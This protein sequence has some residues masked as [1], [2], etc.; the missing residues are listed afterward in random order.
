[1]RRA[2]PV[3]ILGVVLLSTSCTI[4]ERCPGNCD[5]VCGGKM[6]ET[7][8]CAV[9]YRSGYNTGFCAGFLDLDRRG[10][11]EGPFVAGYWDGYSDGSIVRVRHYVEICSSTLAT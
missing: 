3:M 10:D 1:M 2:L 11:K 5:E 8:Q 9:D 4:P 6:F 7:N